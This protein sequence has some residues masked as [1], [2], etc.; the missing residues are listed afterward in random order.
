MTVTRFAEWPIFVAFSNFHT[1]TIIYDS[2]IAGGVIQYSGTSLKGLSELRTQYKKPPQLGQV[3]QPQWYH[4][5]TFLPLKEEN[6]Y[7]TAKMT[8]KWLVPKCPL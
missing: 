2:E 4:A 1:S 3:L 5:N 7:I 8:Q 6:L